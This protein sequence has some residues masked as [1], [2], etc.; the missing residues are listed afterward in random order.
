MNWDISQYAMNHTMQTYSSYYNYKYL[1]EF[2]TD[3]MGHVSIYNESYT[4]DILVRILQDTYKCLRI[5]KC[6]GIDEYV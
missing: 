2:Y 3:E 4:S 1:I 6:P 5:Y